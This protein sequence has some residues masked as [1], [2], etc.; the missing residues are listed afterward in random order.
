MQL[1]S[2]DFDSIIDKLSD[3]FEIK[4]RD[5]GHRQVSI[6]YGNKLVVRTKRSH[7]KK[8]MDHLIDQVRKQF[9]LSRQQ[10]QDLK[11]CPLRADDYRDILINKS[12]I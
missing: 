4:T 3:E 2:K 12:K 10:L 6:Y 1:K 5:T 11:D 7:G 9:F 8:D